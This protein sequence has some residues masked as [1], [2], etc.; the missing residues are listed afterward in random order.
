MHRVVRRSVPQNLT[1][2][3][4]M[5]AFAYRAAP[6]FWR[7]FSKDMKRAVEAAPRRPDLSVWP[8]TGLHA[9]WIG[10][11]SVVL[12][13]DGFIVMTDP[14]FSARIG[15]QVGPATLGLKRLV[16]PALSAMDLPHID[17]VLLSHAH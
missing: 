6:E 10:H 7:R 8:S 16:E 15:I 13:I 2:A 17:L 1:K 9:A 3:G 5:V 14:V 12:S 4:T 11:S